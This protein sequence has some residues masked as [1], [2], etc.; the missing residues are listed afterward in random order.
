MEKISKSRVYKRDHRKQPTR[1][2]WTL[3]ITDHLA[4]QPNHI[5]GW[6]S[7]KIVT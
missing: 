5:I 1:S 7:A 3:A 4:V 2:R 6:E